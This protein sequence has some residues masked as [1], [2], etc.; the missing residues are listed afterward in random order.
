MQEALIDYMKVVASW[1]D[2][3]T[4]AIGV[5]ADNSSRKDPIHT[6]MSFKVVPA[7]MRAPAPL[8]PSARTIPAAIPLPDSEHPPPG[9]A[10]G[11]QR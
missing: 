9:Q 2:E 3:S 10:C 5:E 6:G 1:M 7:G 11:S 4:G 8:S